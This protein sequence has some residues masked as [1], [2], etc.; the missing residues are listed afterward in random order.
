MN[1]KRNAEKA[2]EEEGFPLY[3]LRAVLIDGT[4]S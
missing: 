4:L 3:Q 1:T 2:K